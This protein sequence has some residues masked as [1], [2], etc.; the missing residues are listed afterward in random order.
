MGCM[1]SGRVI[2]L[3]HISHHSLSFAYGSTPLLKAYFF[4]CD[5]EVGN[6]RSRPR[7]ALRTAAFLSES[8]PPCHHMPCLPPHPTRLASTVPPSPTPVAIDTFPWMDKTRPRRAQALRLVIHGSRT[9][10]P[11]SHARTTSLRPQPQYQ[12][13]IPI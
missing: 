1:V 10:Q 7:D 13:H 12:E 9:R 5:C 11:L 8:S 3:I 6:L 2:P 4:I